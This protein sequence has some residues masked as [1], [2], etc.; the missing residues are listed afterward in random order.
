MK[1]D[2]KFTKT[3]TGMMKKTKGVKP[4]PMEMDMPMKP[5][6]HVTFNDLPEA[7]KW[8]LG[9]TY[10]L[11]VQVKMKGMHI[12]DYGDGE[13]GEATLEIQKIGVKS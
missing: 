5:R 11:T 7:K 13:K 9:E 3:S 4:E 10:T 2:D 6:M 8:E 1:K 12:D